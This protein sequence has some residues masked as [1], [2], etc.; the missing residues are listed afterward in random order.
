MAHASVV[1]SL[2][3]KEAEQTILARS[4][5]ALP[6]PGRYRSAERNPAQGAP[7]YQLVDF[8]PEV[9]AM[10]APAS[11]RRSRQVGCSTRG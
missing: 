2:G 10:S 11:K 7:L 3:A 5:E 1:D 8:R 6:S 4:E 9:P